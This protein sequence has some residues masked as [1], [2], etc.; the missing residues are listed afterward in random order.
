M[1]IDELSSVLYSANLHEGTDAASVGWLGTETP[2]T[3]AVG[4]ALVEAIAHLCDYHSTNHEMGLHECELCR[5]HEDGG[6]WWID[7]DEVRYVLPKMTLHYIDRHD[8]L[9]PA[10]FRRVLGEYW[11]ESVNDF[12]TLSFTNY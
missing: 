9:P 5:G 10:L 2:A 8:Y 11:A 6:E 3:G 12:E 1:K 4:P 7:W